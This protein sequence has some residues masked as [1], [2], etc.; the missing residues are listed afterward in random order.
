MTEPPRFEGD[1]W[2]F[3]CGPANTG[4]LHLQF[5]VTG[6]GVVE[7]EYTV[8]AHLCGRPT[9]VHGGIQATLLDEV[10]G[11]AVQAGLPPE[12]AGR[13]SVTAAFSVRYRKPAP[14]GEPLTARGKFLR[15][16]GSNVFVG[17]VL[18]DSAGNELTTAEARWRLLDDMR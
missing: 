15:I 2:C 17:G 16:E 9:V 18:T 8:P 1:A 5:L 3:G 12:L 7:C 6:P 4:G 14:I 10:M 13:R 11:K